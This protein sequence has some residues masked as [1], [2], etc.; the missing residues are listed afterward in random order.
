MSVH[1][2]TRRWALLIPHVSNGLPG[3]GAASTGLRTCFSFRHRTPLTA[4]RSSTTGEWI[5][6]RS[7]KDLIFFSEYFVPVSTT[8]Y[9]GPTRVAN[10]WHNNRLNETGSLVWDRT[11]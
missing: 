10:L 9:N 8:N 4:I 5:T 1:L 6:R 3:I 11:I 2:Y 7:S